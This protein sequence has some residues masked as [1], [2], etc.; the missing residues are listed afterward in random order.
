[1]KSIIKSRRPQFATLNKVNGGS[2]TELV[3]SIDRSLRKAGWITAVCAFSIMVSQ[4]SCKKLVDINPPTSSI[5]TSQVFADSSDAVSAVAGIYASLVN[6]TSLQ[7]GTGAITVFCGLSADELRPFSTDPQLLRVNTNTLID[8]D[9]SS[10]WNEAYPIIYQCNAVLDGIGSSSA[11]GINQATKNQ[12]IGEAKFFRA[13]LYFYLTNMYGDLPYITTIDFKS[14]TLARRIPQSQVYSA[15]VADLLDAQNLLAADFSLGKGER[16]RANKGA[17]TALLSRVYLYMNNT[18]A[19]Y[20]QSTSIINNTSTYSLAS[21]PNGVFVKNNSEAILQFQIKP[22]TGTDYFNATPEGFLFIPYDATSPPNYYLSTEFLNSFENGDLRKSQWIDS[23][24]YSGL[25]YYY[26]YKYNVGPA[27]TSPGG[28]VSQYTMVLRLAEQYLIRA[29]CEANGEGGGLP[30]AI[31]DL[32]TIR[33]RAGLGNLPGNLT[34]AQVLAALAQERRIELFAEWGH[35]WFDLKRTSQVANV[36]K[37]IDY[38]NAYQPFQNLYPIP[39][40]DLS[41]DPNLTQNPGY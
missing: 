7:F 29:E 20:L 15:I 36:F 12:V 33:S 22:G 28:A 24:N 31:K 6:V 18:S 4:E 16:I 40:G 34:S 38:K 23:T 41:T 35:R 1:M 13:Y 5:T 3:S 14:N 21:S 27:Q 19:A 32:N 37:S 9:V 2:F 39:L 8:D 17:A 25:T 11:K 26:P 30:S 10:L